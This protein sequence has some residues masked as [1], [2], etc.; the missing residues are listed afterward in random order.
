MNTI[1]PPFPKLR[2]DLRLHEGTT[3]ERGQAWI[4]E[5][6]ARNK[7]FEIDT[8]SALIL[9]FW[10]AGSPQAIQANAKA[11]AQAEVSLDEINELCEFLTKAGLAEF[12]PFADYAGMTARLAKAKKGWV[13]L[14]VHHYLFFRIPLLKPQKFLERTLPV[15]EF[16]LSIPVVAFVGAL[17]VLGL[18]FASRR[19][20]DFV[21]TFLHFFTFEGAMLYG[22][23]LLFVKAAHEFGHAYMAARYGVRVGTMGIAFLV[24][25]PV[26]YTD[27]TGAWKLRSRRQ[28]FMISAAG[29][30]AELMIAGVSVFVWAFAADGPV[31]TAAYFM[32][33]VSLATSLFMNLNPF[34]RFDGYYLLSD[35]LGVPNLQTRAFALA[36]WRL[37]RAL[38][39]LKAHNPDTLS[40][41]LTG[42]LIAYA[43]SIWAYRL[44]L[45][46][47]IAAYV[48]SFFIK[49]VGIVL[50]I[51]EIGWFVALPVLKELQEWWK[52]REFIARQTHAWYTAAAFLIVVAA[53]CLPCSFSVRVPAILR[54]SEDARIFAPVPSEIVKVNVKEGE[55]VAKG[56]LLFEMRSPQLEK[57][58][59][60]SKQK[61]NALTLRLSRR[62]DDKEDR[63][64]GIVLEQELAAEED[65]LRGYEREAALLHVVSPIDGVVA[66]LPPAMHA[67]RFADL[68]HPLATVRDMSSAVAEG[69]I[70]E[71]DLWRL[72]QGSKGFFI[73]EDPFL[74][75]TSV[76]LSAIAYAASERL[77]IPY[78]ASIY[79]GAI[80]VEQSPNKALHPINA[81]HRLTMTADAWDV[82]Q[83]LRGSVHLEA[84]PES[85]AAMVLRSIARTLIRESGF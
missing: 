34:M 40:P 47:G 85:V 63:S 20:D 9:S 33:S 64:S 48:Y 13:E 84:A 1:A 6:P 53:V 70:D 43:Y 4:V 3:S 77:D 29:M 60:L 10:D 38:F 66:D 75:A 67:G 50:F 81:N 73:P 21:S 41:A 42:F 57:D 36:R 37:R 52:M 27:V 80:A 35:A 44:L 28:R 30:I 54:A 51:I 15:Y 76:Q 31:K 55:Y 25:M 32:A 7:F 68:K 14:A 49:I 26:P 46:I 39:G 19:W 65:K 83:V 18:Y 62:L 45:F 5:D 79:D 16:L 23:C 82:H 61:I 71:N 11:E 69:Y 24:M 59:A 74:R 58:M 72:K 22:I 17:S 2:A 56:Q 8:K 12:E 78:L